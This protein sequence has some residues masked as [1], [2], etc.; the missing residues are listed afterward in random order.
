VLTCVFNATPVPRDSYAVG[1]SEAG[2]YRKVL[3]TDDTRFG[4]SGYN[5]QAA[6]EASDQGAQGYPYSI[7][8]NLPPLGAMFFSGPA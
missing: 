3:D 6:V 7:R 2:Q 1:V 8:L 5:R 4:G